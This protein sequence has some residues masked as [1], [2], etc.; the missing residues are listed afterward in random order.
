MFFV[1]Q[2]GLSKVEFT[3]KAPFM[4]F[5]LVEFLAEFLVFLILL[6]EESLSKFAGTAVGLLLLSI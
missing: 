6:R 1:D 3:L 4:V 2:L 5:Q